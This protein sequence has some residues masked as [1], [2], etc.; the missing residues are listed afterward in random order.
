MRLA[1]QWLP[2][3]LSTLDLR[4]LTSATRPR[5]CRQYRASVAACKDSE[6]RRS[7]PKEPRQ[8]DEL[9]RLD[10]R[11]QSSGGQSLVRTPGGGHRTAFSEVALRASLKKLSPN[12]E[13]LYYESDVTSQT[14]GSSR[15]VD[16]ADYMHDPRLWSR[17]LQFR[18]RIHGIEGVK[19]IW[20]GLHKRKIVVPS[21]GPE[22]DTLW[23]GF[24]DAAMGN[25]Q[26]LDELLDYS[27]TLFKEHGRVW[28]CFYETVITHL[29]RT[30]TSRA[31]LVHRRLKDWCPLPQDYLA[32]I[33]RSWSGTAGSLNI[34]ARIYR[35]S[36]VRDLYAVIVPLLCE[37]GRYHDAYRWHRFLIQHGDVP[38][39][40]APAQSLLWYMA[41]WGDSLQLEA[42]TKSLRVAGGQ[43]PGSAEKDIRSDPIFSREEMNKK[44][45]KL[46]FISE[47]PFNDSFWARLFATQA[48]SVDVIINGLRILGINEIGPL[49]LRELAVREGN[50]DSVLQRIEQMS[51][52]GISIGSSKF[53]KLVKQ[54]ASD[55]ENELLEELLASDQHPDVLEDRDLQEALLA[56]YLEANDMRQVRKTL[57]ILTAFKGDPKTLE[58]NLILRAHLRQRNRFAVEHVLHDMDDANVTLTSKSSRALMRYLLRP[59]NMGKNPVVIPRMQDDLGLTVRVLLGVLHSGGA[60]NPKIWGEIFRRLGMAGRLDELERLA[61]WLACFY[62]SSGAKHQYAPWGATLA[63]SFKSAALAYVPEDVQSNHATHPLRIIFSSAL[64][65]SIIA[66]YFKSEPKDSNNS[67]GQFSVSGFKP[68]TRGLRLLRMLAE[69]GV[70]VQ[71]THIRQAF[72][73]RLIILYGP[74]RSSRSLNRRLPQS[75]LI[76]MRTMIRDAEEVLGSTLF[77]GKKRWWDHLR[78]RETRTNRHT[79]PKLYRDTNPSSS[80]RE[81][82]IYADGG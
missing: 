39:S 79:R 76:P 37:R 81:S 12:F 71:K 28:T 30:D 23:R 67:D 13:W 72:I 41:R 64:Q 38:A 17:L 40:M 32:R 80:L 49:C 46:F 62:N 45:G 7:P 74:G 48:F 51:K 54:F 33:T 65:K 14:P 31:Y 25:H 42:V 68:W 4:L 63:S 11:H 73:K 18:R 52:S 3:G 5:R 16:H 6:S 34:L 50:P 9:L 55:K 43:F 10:F 66:W 75:N 70:Y 69:R 36:S 58:Y 78:P 60:L 59:R 24:L 21:N 27:E 22:A 47:K 29:L 15:L 77:N 53:S 8:K 2:R 26:M 61:L 82:V 19:A 57:A 20:K 1:S 44:F 56:S 35:E